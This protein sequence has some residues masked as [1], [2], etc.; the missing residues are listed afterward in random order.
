MFILKQYDK[1][2]VEFEILEDPLNGQSCHITK[3]YEEF[4]QLFPIGITMTDKGLMSW[5]E[6]R[7]IPKN[8]EFVESFLAKNG[9][10]R[11]DTKGIMQICLGLSLNDAYWVVEEG[12]DGK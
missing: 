6:S 7:I 12:F 1:P 11:R 8:R 3:L 9:L 10:S 5:L 2:L 4:E